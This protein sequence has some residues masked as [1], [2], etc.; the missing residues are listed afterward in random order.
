ME[1]QTEFLGYFKK[2]IK[3]SNVSVK[4]DKKKKK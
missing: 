4:F 2:K 1:D 3:K